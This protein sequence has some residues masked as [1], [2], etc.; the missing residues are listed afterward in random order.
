MIGL[1][2]KRKILDLTFDPILSHGTLP[3]TEVSV[4]CCSATSI[5]SKERAL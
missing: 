5:F 2:L 1:I 4:S 3:G